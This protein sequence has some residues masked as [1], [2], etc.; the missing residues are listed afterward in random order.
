[1][2]IQDGYRKMHAKHR[3]NNSGISRFSMRRVTLSISVRYLHCL[4]ELQSEIP[5]SHFICLINAHP[6]KWTIRV[7][8][9]ISPSGFATTRPQLNSVFA[10]NLSWRFSV[11]A[12]PSCLSI[13]EREGHQWARP[14]ENAPQ[15]PTVPPARGG[16]HVKF[17]DKGHP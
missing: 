11:P 9:G 14:D 10:S 8:L 7:H 13:P 12:R 16:Y 1:M 2:I 3:V 4:D 15:G 6:V 5:K 17:P